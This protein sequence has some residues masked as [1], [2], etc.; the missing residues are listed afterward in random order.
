MGWNDKRFVFLI[1]SQDWKMSLPW[2]DRITHYFL[3]EEFCHSFTDTN[4]NAENIIHRLGLM[5]NLSHTLNKC[6]N[7]KMRRDKFYYSVWLFCDGLVI[8]VWPTDKSV[9]CASSHSYFSRETLHHCEK[10]GRNSGSGAQP[11]PHFLLNHCITA[12]MILSTPL[13]TSLRNCS[14]S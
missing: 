7:L 3:P 10:L 1:V 13:Q 8:L 4:T 5:Q 11:I 12:L 9:H 14:V 2:E 6:N